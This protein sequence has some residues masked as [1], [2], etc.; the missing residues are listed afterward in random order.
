MAT[1]TVNFKVI[2]VNKTTAEW[3]SF[4]EV[5]SKGVLCIEWTTN[6]SVLLKIGDGVDTW[7]NLPYVKDGSFNIADYYTK[8]EVY[9]KSETD[10]A[11]S[12]EIGKLGSVLNIKGIKA[13]TGELPTQDNTVGDLW[14]VGTSGDGTNVYDEYVWTTENK[15]ENIGKA[16]TIT[17]LTNYFTKSEV[18]AITDALD[19][20]VKTL[21]DNALQEGDTVIINCTT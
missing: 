18:T 7:G 8:S 11:I 9:T 3:A 2:Q 10:S 20:R 5:V 1:R 4:S 6:G 19:A 14:F 17:D 16:S 12:T 13:T 15:W 21:E